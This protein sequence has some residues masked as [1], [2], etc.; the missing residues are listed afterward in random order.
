MEKKTRVVKRLK[1]VKAR[2][3]RE[4]IQLRSGPYPESLT[5]QAPVGASDIN[6]I[7]KKARK[8]GLMPMAMN[9]RQALF[10]D[11]SQVGTYHEALNAIENANSQFMAL[12][13]DIRNEFE[14]DPQKFMEFMSDENNLDKAVEMGLVDLPATAPASGPIPPQ[15]EPETP[16][17]G[18][19]ET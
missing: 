3:G 14:N 6:A 15:D 13:S 18:S 10:G 7:M 1:P 19:N 8:T 2:K 11:F 5:K 12:P 9:E 16:S 17:E 4:R